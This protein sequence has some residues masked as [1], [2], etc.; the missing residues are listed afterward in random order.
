[1]N[2]EVRTSITAR[3]FPAVGKHKVVAMASITLNEEFVITGIRVVKGC[4][5]LFVSF[6]QRKDKD[7]DYDDIAF[8]VTSPAYAKAKEVILREY[9]EVMNREVG[10]GEW[11]NTNKNHQ[12]Q[13]PFEK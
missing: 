8:P 9:E 3:V 6:P 4:N 11:I 7:G 1:M 13:I 10:K 2:D 5:G 12:E